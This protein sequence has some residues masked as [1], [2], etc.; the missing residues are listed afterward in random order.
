[1]KDTRVNAVDEAFRYYKRVKEQQMTLREVE[2]TLASQGHGVDF[3]ID[4]TDKIERMI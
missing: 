1:M 3:V 4:V 2:D